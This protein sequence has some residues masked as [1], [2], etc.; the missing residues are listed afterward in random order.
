MS[1]GKEFCS[2]LLSEEAST[3]ICVAK[4]AHDTLI[5]HQAVL[6]MTSEVAKKCG[7]KVV[8]RFL[9]VIAVIMALWII[10]VKPVLILFLILYLQTGLRR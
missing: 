4:P 7:I 9:L 8:W 5:K 3:F 1:I 6:N 2:V 10:N